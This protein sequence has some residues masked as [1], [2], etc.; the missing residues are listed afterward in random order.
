MFSE[1][2]TSVVK[3]GGIK[4]KLDCEHVVGVFGFFMLTDVDF[5][6]GIQNDIENDE[7]KPCKKEP[8]AGWAGHMGSLKVIINLRS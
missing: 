8:G 5:L 1:S 7:G 3:Q 4:Y 2:V 6:E